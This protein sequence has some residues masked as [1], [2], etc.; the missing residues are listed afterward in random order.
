MLYLKGY[1]STSD[2]NAPLRVRDSMPFKF[3]VFSGSTAPGISIP[4]LHRVQTGLA[5]RL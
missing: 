5:G 3:G 2:F 4:A 1:V